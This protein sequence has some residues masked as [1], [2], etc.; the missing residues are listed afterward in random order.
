MSLTLEGGILLG[1]SLFLVV[2]LVVNFLY[3][4]QIFRFRLPGDASL[5]VLGI[6]S[7]LMMTVLIASSVTILGK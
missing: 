3:V 2:I 6:H 1:Y 7:A 4:F 5:V